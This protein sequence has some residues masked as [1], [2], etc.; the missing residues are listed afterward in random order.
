VLVVNGDLALRQAVKSTL[1]T[2]GYQV[3]LAACEEAAIDLLRKQRSRISLVLWDLP[4]PAAERGGTAWRTRWASLGLP[5]V[6]CAD[7]GASPSREDASGFAEVLEK[8]YTPAKL[9]DAVGSVL[10]SSRRG[11]A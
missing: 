10:S 3:F 8:P 5:V 4:A 6:F 7:P 11:A 2:H 1:E 9:L